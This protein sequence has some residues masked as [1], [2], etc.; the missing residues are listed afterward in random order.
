MDFAKINHCF[1][2]AI[3]QLAEQEI[4]NLQKAPL[5]EST[6]RAVVFHRA[7]RKIKGYWMRVSSGI[8]FVRTNT[9][10]YDSIQDARKSVPTGWKKIKRD[11]SDKPE[12][13]ETWMSK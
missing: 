11:N 6:K 5:T 8:G 10:E 1:T 2:T 4:E 12:I 7:G 9:K 13:I 3:S